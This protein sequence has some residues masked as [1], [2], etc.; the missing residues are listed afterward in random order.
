MKQAILITAYKNYNHLEEII[1]FFD[2]NFE[3]YIHI[4]KKSKISKIELINL[5]KYENVKLVSRKFNVNWGGLNH[6]KCILYLC[7]QALKNPDIYYLHLISGSDYP[8]QKISSF[9]DF[10]K[11]NSNEEYLNYFEIPRPNGADNG[12]MDR[13][14]YYNLY[15]VLNAKIYNQNRLIRK[16]I[17]LQKSIGFKRSISTKIPKLYSGST[18]WSLSRE[19]VQYVMKFTYENKFLLK[20]MKY[21]LCSEEIY[22]QTIILNSKFALKVN[23]NTLRYIDW[24]AR[25]GN[26]PVILDEYDYHKIIKSDA[27]FARK[28]EYPQSVLLMNQIKSFLEI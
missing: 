23:Q 2:E 18:W 1:N 4:D 22:F 3:L 7:E 11:I 26:N 6:L 19:C 9:L 12:G 15:D 13:I 24:V 21:T 10:F 5:N 25:N 8:I 27:F 16:F 17:G 28:I 20:R 14:E